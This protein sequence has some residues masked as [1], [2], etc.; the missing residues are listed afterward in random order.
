MIRQILRENP[1]LATIIIG[2]ILV[3]AWMI[4]KIRW[5]LK[6][7]EEFVAMA[8]SSDPKKIILGLKFLKKR[9]KDISNYIHVVLPFCVSDSAIYRVSAQMILQKYYPDDF[10]LIKGYSGAEKLEICRDKVSELYEKY[11]KV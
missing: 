8:Q 5:K 7:D 6:P 1:V 4:D 3:I 9:N 11:N 2:S 10:A